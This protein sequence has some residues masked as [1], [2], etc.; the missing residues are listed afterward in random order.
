MD[1]DRGEGEGLGSRREAASLGVDE[2][3]AIVVDA[4]DIDLEGGREFK[5]GAIGAV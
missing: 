4:E 3:R 2:V 1:A 5:S